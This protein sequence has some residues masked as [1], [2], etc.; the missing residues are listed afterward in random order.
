MGFRMKGFAWVFIFL[1][2][3]SVQAANVRLI[4]EYTPNPVYP[5]DLLRAKEGGEVRV[6]FWVNS[7]GKV[8]DL[9]V[10]ESSHYEF[11][12]AVKR[13]VKQWRFK[14]WTPT[15]QQPARLEINAPF[16]FSLGT[17]AIWASDM[18]VVLSSLPCSELNEE[19]A[20]TRQ[21]FPDKPLANLHM[22]GYIR[23]YLSGTFVS[24]QL[25]ATER[26][27]MLDDLDRAIPRILESCEENPTAKYVDYL[28]GD[29]RKLF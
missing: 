9:K 14:P 24:G 29:M 23:A 4:P 15:D 18:N 28:P 5:I 10:L 2:S 25:S 20:E 21:Y 6:K 1:L 12:R 19:L 22:F 16:L 26:K 8:S 3:M 13:V 17:G 7:D 11:V 27:I